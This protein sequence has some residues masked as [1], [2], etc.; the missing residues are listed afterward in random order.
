MAAIFLVGI[1]LGFIVLDGATY[2]LLVLMLMCHYRLAEANALKV[3]LIAVTT[4]IPIAL[5]GGAGEIAWAEG[6][7]LAAGSVVGGHIGAR[8][9]LQP[10]ARVWAF[11]ILVVAIVLELAHLGW[12]YSAPYRAA[13]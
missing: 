10:L 8:L 9:S 1:W 2:L 3:L 13:V 6:G 11:R 12:H 5:F 4:V 7:V